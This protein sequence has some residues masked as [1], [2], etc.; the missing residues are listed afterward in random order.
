[1][2]VQ[3]HHAQ[4]QPY[5]QT[6]TF[7]CISAIYIS[8]LCVMNLLNITRFISFDMNIGSTTLLFSI[9]IGMLPYPLTFLCTDIVA[10]CYGK[11]A[12]NKLVTTGLIANLWM[13]LLLWSLGWLQ[14]PNSDLIV[15]N[16]DSNYAFYFIRLLSMTAII[17]SMLAYLVAQYLDVFLFH[18][19]KKLTKNKHLWLRNN[20]STM[21]SQLVDTVIVLTCTYFM[22]KHMVWDQPNSPAVSIYMVILTSYLFK[23]AIAILDTLPCYFFVWLIKRQ[24]KI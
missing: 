13:L 12:A 22:T 19:L 8:T 5:T 1:M 18:T 23:C 10:E 15:P 24:Q 7:L 17:S 3:S 9:P 14:P 16:D 6:T 11:K 2:P 20:V 21:V 4:H